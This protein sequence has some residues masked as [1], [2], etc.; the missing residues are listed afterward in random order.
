MTDA[1]AQRD[2]VI[3]AVGRFGGLDHLVVGAGVFGATQT[4]DEIT[5]EVW[6]SVQSVNLD[7]V[8]GL[9]GAAH[10]LLARSP[11][12]GS[13]V[14]IGSKNVAAPGRGAAAYSTSKAALD[15]LARIAALEWAEDGI[16]VNSVHPDGVFDTGLWSDELVAQRAAHYG[17]TVDEY[18]SRNLLSVE[19]TSDLVAG[20]VVALC[21]PTFA[22]TTGAGVPIDG[23][24]DRII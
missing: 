19:V 21:G 3:E 20:A 18:R 15:Q 12:G 2:A 13:V 23:G 9:L 7:S 5:P 24:S 1:D 16:R 10:P 6:R 8:V 17:L 4:I 11:V 22:A 14:V